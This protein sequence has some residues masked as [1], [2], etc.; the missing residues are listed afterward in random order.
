MVIGNRIGFIIG[1]TKAYLVMAGV[2]I[3]GIALLVLG[4]TLMA[5]MFLSFLP[6]FLFLHLSMLLST[7]SIQGVGSVV[8]LPLGLGSISITLTSVVYLFV[9][10]GSIMYAMI[11][12]FVCA[13]LFVLA[14]FT[15]GIVVN[16]RSELVKLCTSPG[17]LLA[18][19]RIPPAGSRD[20]R[21]Q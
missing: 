19:P 13:V 3:G 9:S 16:I 14:V 20:R 12:A 5:V 1:M 10:D 18:T 11:A 2:V 6:V 17:L 7:G 4:H 21:D 8:M 15:G